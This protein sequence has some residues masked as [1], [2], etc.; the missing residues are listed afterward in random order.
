MPKFLVT[1]GSYFQPFT[2]DELSKPVV[3][4]VEAHNAAQD[5]YDQLSMETSALGRYIT[6]NPDDVNAKRM[7]DS[8]LAKLNSLQDN[9]WNNGYNAATRRDLASARA[10]YASDIIRLQ[11]AIK[12]RQERSQEYWKTRHE[13]PD[14]IMGRDPGES[15][16]DNYLFN[17]LY[18]RDYYSYSG[19]DF[20]KMV[21]AEASA[22]ASEML[23]DPQVKKNP[24]LVGYLQMI[25]R[26][27]FTNKQVDDAYAAVRKAVA[28]DMSD[29]ANL[30]FAT[31]ILANVLMSNLESSGAKGNVSQDEFNRLLDYGKIGL[32]QAV[33]KTKVST[34]ADLQWA[35]QQKIARENERYQHQL[36][37]AAMKAAA[38]NGSGGSDPR[39]GPRIAT[40]RGNALNG[41]SDKKQEDE[42]TDKKNV[43]D[44]L[45]I[46]N[47]LKKSGAL[48]QPNGMLSDAANKAISKLIRIDVFGNEHVNEYYQKITGGKKGFITN[49]D[50]DPILEQIRNEIN[51]TES[52]DHMY[53]FN[54]TSAAAANMAR[55]VFKPNIGQLSGG[56]RNSTVAESVARYADGSAVKATDLKTILESDNLLVGF[57]AKSGKITV[58]RNAADD[59]QD[60]GK[61][62]DKI[63]YLDPKTVLTGTSGY[64]NSAALLYAFNSAIPEGVSSAKEEEYR[65]K[66]AA[67]ANYGQT[68]DLR[69]MADLI[70]ENYKSMMKDGSDEDKAV[71]NALVESFAQGLFDSSNTAWSPNN[72]KEGWSAKTGGDAMSYGY[73][74]DDDY[75]FE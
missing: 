3:Q 52:N 40:L 51:N 6:E 27:G 44:A 33:G 37:L 38:R 61:Y 15:G 39:I 31:G 69:M 1:S 8:Y 11:A 18:G 64:A 32:S 24:M 22:R 14:M 73:G 2:Y 25:E 5:A 20:A 54:V 7:Y 46:I 19:N 55:T 28:G 50:L 41:I 12:A 36:N 49:T 45:S 66:I 43:Y 47:E 16:L 42:F 23:N 68:V 70:H 17:D 9:L 29:V 75:D 74:D 71:Y 67:L 57:D 65:N 60:V 62:N 30:D 59:S 48:R 35:E 10:G 26:D 63:V 53:Q 34:V 72:Y 21:G 56:K 13:H 4:T 58:Q